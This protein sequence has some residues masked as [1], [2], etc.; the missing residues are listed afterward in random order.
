MNKKSFLYNLINIIVIALAVFIFATS[1][2]NAGVFAGANA[3]NIAVI[4][5]AAIIVHS[6]K[7]FRLY[8]ALY[9]ANISISR[10]I[11]IYC[12]VTP[13]SI[14]FPFKLGELFRIYCYGYS[15]GD[16]LK[17]IVTVILDR[18][19]DTAALVTMIIVVWI[20]S[21]GLM[22]PLVYILLVF[23]V[24]AILL[25]AAFPGLYLYWKK[26]LL[27]ADATPKKLKA[28]KYLESTN[29][30]YQEILGITKGRGLILY[31]I[32]VIAWIAEMSSVAVLNRLD[33]GTDINSKLSEYLTSALSNSQSVQLKQFIFISV[34]MLI[35]LYLIVK[36]IETLRGERK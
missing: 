25:F 34:V 3:A 11:K 33:S 19:M 4:I 23:L 2:I 27:R 8:L 18:F 29:R 13:I 6:L 16:M 14:L 24:A 32:S 12:K 22:M 35:V 7:A 10:Y 15:T 26:H 5:F 31:I 30:V 9:G 17:G 36:A 1:Y 21:G 28:L 20:A